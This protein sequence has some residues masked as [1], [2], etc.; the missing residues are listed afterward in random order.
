MLY[1]FLICTDLEAIKC[2]VVMKVLR[3]QCTKT[4]L[5]EGKHTVCL[6]LEKKESWVSFSILKH[7]TQY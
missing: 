4:K 5:W 7:R 2:H 6:G 1:F 3:K